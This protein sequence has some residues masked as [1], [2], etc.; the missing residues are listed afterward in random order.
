MLSTWVTSLY[1]SL[2]SIHSVFIRSDKVVVSLKTRR[3]SPSRR[4]LWIGTQ[5]HR[6]LPY[7]HITRLSR[8]SHTSKNRKRSGSP[9]IL[10]KNI[11]YPIMLLYSDIRQPAQTTAPLISNLLKSC[12][13][14]FPSL[15]L[16]IKMTCLP[17]EC[18][19]EM[20][21]TDI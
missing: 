12:S 16:L 18:W 17:Q 11:C 7:I 10:Q 21:V 6:V 5:T 3:S 20:Y 9:L 19:N 4:R 1:F 15:L 2:Q 8:N 14:V 13:A